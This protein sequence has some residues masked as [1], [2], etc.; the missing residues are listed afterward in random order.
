MA[1]QSEKRY[2]LTPEAGS[3]QYEIDHDN[4]TISL[5]VDIE[6]LSEDLM[7]DDTFKNAIISAVAKQLTGSDETTDLTAAIGET[8][9]KA[10]IADL[11]N[12]DTNNNAEWDAAKDVNSLYT[13]IIT[14]VMSNNPTSAT[15]ATTGK[16]YTPLIV[17]GTKNPNDAKISENYPGAY[18]YI[19]HD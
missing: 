16:G 9:I 8:A 15:D 17:H 2:V 11:V 7:S 4:Q 10:A 6:K 5:R 14:T 18:I 1:E 12:A 13:A 3:V 19:Q